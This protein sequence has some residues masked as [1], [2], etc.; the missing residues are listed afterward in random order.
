MTFL[1][2]AN[3]FKKFFDQFQ[4][5]AAKYYL[6]AGNK[7]KAKRQLEP[8]IKKYQISLKIKPNF[9]PSLIKLGQVYQEKENLHSAFD[10]YQKVLQIKPDHIGSQIES[11][12]TLRQQNNYGEAAGYPVE[13]EARKMPGWENIWMRDVWKTIVY[14]R[15]LRSDLQVFVI[16][17]D[18]GIGI[19]KKGKPESMLPYSETEINHLTYQDFE[20]NKEKLLNLKSPDYFNSFLA[21]QVQQVT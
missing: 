21:K 18:C 5:E 20:Q 4:N 8:A 19:V 13:S 16:D 2:G 6:K 17:C 9:I 12:K 11:A 1:K 10:Y 7:L 15:S 14:L 3:M